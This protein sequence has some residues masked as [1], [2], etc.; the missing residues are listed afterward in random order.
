MASITLFIDTTNDSLVAGLTSTQVFDAGSLP[1]FYGDSP[2][3]N[4]YL[5]T[6]VY[7][8]G[9]SGYTFAAPNNT[10]LSVQLFLDDGLV[11]GTI[12][13][14]Q[15]VF[16]PDVNNSF[17][18]ATLPL[19]TP[20]L[21]TLLGSNT[22]ASC[23]M[24]IG[25]LKNGVPTTVLSQRVNIGVGLPNVVP[26][27]PA[28]QTAISAETASATFVNKTPVNGEPIYFASPAGKIFALVAVDQDDGTA[29]GTISPVN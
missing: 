24:K 17:V 3:I 28:G 7:T 15:T 11:G 23:W 6:R 27:V 13:T 4:I 26:V 14:F 19:N 2:T 25:Y 9:Q 21:A 29:I 12:Y 16:V 20:A 22:N 8:A 10:G 18:T 5:L 1:F